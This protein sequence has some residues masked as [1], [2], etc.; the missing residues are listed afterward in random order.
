MCERRDSLIEVSGAQPPEAEIT[1]ENPQGGDQLLSGAS[2]A[3]AGTVEHELSYLHRLPTAGICTQGVDQRGS[4][5]GILA[6][7]G[8]CPAAVLSEPIAKRDD[9]FGF[10]PV[11]IWPAVGLA[12][13]CS[14]QVGVKP[15]C[16]EACMVLV[17]SA[18]WRR[19]VTTG[20]VAIKGFERAR[21]DHSKGATPA[22]QKA[23]KMAC[24]AQVFYGTQRRVT[25]PC[26]SISKAVDVRTT[27]T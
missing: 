11:G 24:R 17:S 7:C 1:Q 3:V 10:R 6:Q 14:D 26:E 15:F 9:Q 19:A 13:P 16:P 23:A 2:P 21:I 18:V 4:D 20:Q 5:T 25:V 27:E 8:L 12:N 22:L